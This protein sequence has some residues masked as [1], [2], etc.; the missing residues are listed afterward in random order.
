MDMSF[1]KTTKGLYAL[2]MAATALVVTVLL[3]LFPK[4]EIVPGFAY[5]LVVSFLFDVY[6]QRR[7]NDL[8][9]LGMDWR[10]MIFVGAAAAQIGLVYLWR[11]GWPL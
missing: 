6:L 9:P 4:A 5:M 7:S 8:D 1:F 2:I 11:H 10:A 3:I